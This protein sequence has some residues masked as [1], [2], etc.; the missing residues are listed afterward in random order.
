NGRGQTGSNGRG[1]TGSNGRAI[2]VADVLGQTGSN[3]RGQTGSNGRGQTGSNGR[4]DTVADV[5]GQTGSNGRGQTGSNGR[6]QT[7]S[8]GRAV[9]SAAMG[10][11]ERLGATGVVVL[12]QE[13]A[14]D[15]TNANGVAAGDYV[16]V[17]VDEGG[18]TLQKIEDAY[19]PGVSPVVL[20]GVVN[21]VD[22]QTAKLIIGGV[23][24]DYSSQ[25]A[26]NPG[27]LPTAGAIYETVG[28]Q[29]APGGVILAG[30]QYD[31]AVLSLS[32]P[33]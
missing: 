1:Q 21:G 5:L 4:A 20:V 25:L 17:T 6:G 16:L 23:S 19:V 8:N 10:V 30:L 11:V 13:F 15:A 29:P 32:R 9:T 2:T 7:G 3:G 18:A 31:G 27:L 24:V 22:V 12:G 33:Q 28:I 26:L 14:L